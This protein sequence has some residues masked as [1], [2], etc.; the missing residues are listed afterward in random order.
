[1][2]LFTLFQL[3]SLNLKYKRQ[4]TCHLLY[5]RKTFFTAA[6]VFISM[7]IKAQ[8]TIPDADTQI[9]MAI[10]AAPADKREGAKVYGYAK[11]GTFVVLREGSNDFVCIADDPKK[12]DIGVSCYQKELDTF[13]ERGRKL[14]KEGKNQK[15]I[16]DIREKEVKDGTLKMPGQP[17]TL[18]VLS[19]DHFRGRNFQSLI[20]Q[21]IIS[22]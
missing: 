4:S 16:F 17:S 10:L 2:S 18:Y 12:D 1:M 11:D 19:E 15:D 22:K 13:M 7:Q 3:R 9:K 21:D 5:M 6:V 20:V 8:S 14:T